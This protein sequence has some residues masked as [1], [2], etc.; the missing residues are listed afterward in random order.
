MATYKI[1]DR[2]RI[3]LAGSLN[4]GMEAVVISGL[5]RRNVWLNGNH[6]GEREVYDVVVSGVGRIGVNG[7][8]LAYRP[9][10]LE[11]IQPTPTAQEI[12]EMSAPPDWTIPLPACVGVGE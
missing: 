5:C 2:V 12:C 6:L 4:N 3:R 9:D 11:P 8:Q 7:H 1:G 10:Q